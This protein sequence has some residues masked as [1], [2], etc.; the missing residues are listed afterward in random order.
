MDKLF[1]KS[2]SGEKSAYQAEQIETPSLNLHLSLK[3][4]LALYI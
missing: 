3:I 2:T 1:I 4:A